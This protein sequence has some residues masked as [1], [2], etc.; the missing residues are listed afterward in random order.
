LD[1]KRA[2]PCG[3]QQEKVLLEEFLE[4]IFEEMQE[5][6]VRAIPQERPKIKTGSFSRFFLNS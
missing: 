3:A 1:L 5:Y 6:R 2:S 4:R